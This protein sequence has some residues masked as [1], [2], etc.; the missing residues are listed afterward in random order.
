MGGDAGRDPYR[1]RPFAGI[2]GAQ[3]LVGQATGGGA[4]TGQRERVGEAGAERRRARIRGGPVE[5]RGARGLTVAAGG[6]IGQRVGQPVV[7]QP[8][9]GQTQREIR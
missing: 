8:V 7:A 6:E 1:R 2:L 9:L 5:P 4:V 3:Q